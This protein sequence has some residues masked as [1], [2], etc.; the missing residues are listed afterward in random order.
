MD[1]VFRA[2]FGFL[3]VY[4]LTRVVG[5]RELSSMEPF[6]LILLVMIGDLVQ[7]GVTQNDFSVTGLVLAAGT[8][9]LMTVLV[10][11]ADFRVPWIRPALAGEPIIVLQD[12]EPIE[13]NLRRNRMTVEELAAEARQQG[14]ESLDKARWAVLEPNGTV[15]FIQA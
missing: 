9:A 13:R 10:A 1:I 3:F 11:Y 15:S 4:F 6:D 2:A 5:R 14:L 8:V 12:G 7:Q